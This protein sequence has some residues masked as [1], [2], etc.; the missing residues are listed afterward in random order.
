MHVWLFQAKDAYKLTEKVPPR[1][2]RGDSWLAKRYRDDM[3]VGDKVIL[4]QSGPAAGV[5]AFGEL[6]STP[7]EQPSDE[8]GDDVEWRVDIRYSE[9]L[10]HPLFKHELAEQPELQDLLVVRQPFAANPFRVQT[11]E[12]ETIQELIAEKG[13]RKMMRCRWCGEPHAE[14]LCGR[15]PGKLRHGV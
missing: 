5:Y 4:W 10:E 15:R 14:P 2:G 7:Y 13:R 3:E 8:N 1:L 6:A 12:W 9:L 11:E